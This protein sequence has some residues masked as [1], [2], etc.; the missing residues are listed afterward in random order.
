M[1]CVLFMWTSFTRSGTLWKGTQKDVKRTGLK[2][3]AYIES[4]GLKPERPME[5]GLIFAPLVIRLNDSGCLVLDQL[6]HVKRQMPPRLL[7]LFLGLEGKPDLEI[8]RFSKKWGSLGIGADGWRSSFQGETEPIEGWRIF[9]GRI[10]AAINIGAEF[11]QGRPGYEA[12]WEAMTHGENRYQI[13]KPWKT[14][15]PYTDELQGMI[16]AMISRFKVAPR[17]WWNRERHQWQI[18][19]DASGPSN[20]PG[21]LVIQLM[22]LIADKDGFAICSSCHKS[23]MPDRR[24][25]PTR[26]NY[27]IDE[28]CRKAAWRDAK[29]DLRERQRKETTNGKTR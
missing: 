20:L 21:L 12:D 2:P 24:P 17:F 26:R 28:A 6:K 22:L 25:D 23:Y 18:D 16:R 3:G 10:K 7:P 19:L 8:L 14:R 15:E 1:S 11:H 4:K 27:C 13:F 5:T 29:R 9:I